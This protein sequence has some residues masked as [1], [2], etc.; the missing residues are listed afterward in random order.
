MSVRLNDRR[1]F[2]K[3]LGDTITIK[4]WV[5]RQRGFIIIALENNKQGIVLI[6]DGNLGGSS[7][8]SKAADIW[9]K[10]GGIFV[11]A[12]GVLRHS[13]E[14]AKDNKIKRSQARKFFYFSTKELELTS[15]RTAVYTTK[16][17]PVG[18]KILATDVREKS[19]ERSSVPDVFIS[20][21]EEAIGRIVRSPLDAGELVMKTSLSSK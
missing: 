4:G 6:D 17:I 10:Y 1:L 19:I 9:S 16:K 21:K 8:A 15:G 5:R 12:K 11:T 3:D 2:Q 7:S 18:A 13:T 14:L 20:K